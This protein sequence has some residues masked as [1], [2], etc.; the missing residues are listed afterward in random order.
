MV[1]AI[2]ADATVY[3]GADDSRQANELN[4]ETWNYKLAGSYQ[5]DNHRLT[6]GYELD[7]LEIFNLFI[8][9][10]YTREPLRP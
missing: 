10:V 6:F 1:T 8:Q 7:D 9:H 2:L 4:Y 3:F 5:L